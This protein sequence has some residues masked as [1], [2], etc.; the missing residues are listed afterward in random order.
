MK[1]ERSWKASISVLDLVLVLVLAVEIL[2]KEEY[3]S[4]RNRRYIHIEI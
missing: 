1:E 3:P 2:I 4:I